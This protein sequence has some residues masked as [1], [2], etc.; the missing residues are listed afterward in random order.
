MKYST[1]ELYDIDPKVLAKMTY[2]D[3]LEYKLKAAKAKLDYVV[4]RDIPLWAWT[5]EDDKKHKELTK[6]IK[7]CE[8]KLKEIKC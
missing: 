5:D 3:A 4:F 1:Q 8:D 7:W 6:A 2:E